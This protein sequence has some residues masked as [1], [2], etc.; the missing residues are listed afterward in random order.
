MPLKFAAR[1]RI[2]SIR[3]RRGERFDELSDK[4][5]LLVGTVQ[6]EV[7]SGTA[8]VDRMSAVS[9]G[10]HVQMPEDTVP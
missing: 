10:I 8:A 2:R 4:L 7:K 5:R 6:W 1:G 9:D 3:R